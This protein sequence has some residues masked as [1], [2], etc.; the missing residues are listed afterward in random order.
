MSRKHL[1]ISIVVLVAVC[2][3]ASVAYA[4]LTS[5]ASVAGNTISTGSEFGMTASSNPIT[6]S[7]LVPQNDPPAAPN[8][9]TTGYK[10]S[11]VWFQNNATIPAMAF[12][13][14]DNLT[15]PGNIRDLVNVKITVAP[16][17]SGWGDES[18]TLSGPGGPYVVY[19]GPISGIWGQDNGKA[20]MSTRYWNGSSW[21]HTPIAAG[22]QGWYKIVVWLDSTATNA[23]MGQTLTCDLNFWGTQE[24]NWAD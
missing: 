19:S 18:A 24:E 11:F 4:W 17:D 2:I 3:F 6:V 15:D 10:T 5:T 8:A 1:F 20:N 22:Q 21:V 7:G 16:T 23:A 9:D 12:A 14:L 13:Y